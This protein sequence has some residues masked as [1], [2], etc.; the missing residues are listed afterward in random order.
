MS[1]PCPRIS[2]VVPA[3]DEERWLPRLL[4][5]VDRARE[6]Y[7]Q[8]DQAV[9]VIVAD[10]ASTDGTHDVAE[11][12]GCLVEVVERRSIAAV[13]NGGAR[14]ARGGILAFADADTRLH[15]RTFHVIDALLADEDVIGGATGVVFE[16][17]SPGIRCTH[18]MLVLVAMMLRGVR[19]RRP[20]SLDS[21]VVFCRREDFFEV[22]GYREDLLFAED[23]GLLLALTRL[24]RARA[25]T[26]MSGTDAR[27]VSSARKFD[28]Y[29]DWH[30]FRM[31]WHILR[32]AVTGHEGW[33]RSYWYPPRDRS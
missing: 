26:W 16:R 5:S 18:A 24:A 21:G 19:T 33:I 17:S 3:H 14:V 10:N 6:A 27:A 25:Q 20:L 7:G 22:G 28:R 31:P 32:F 12:R 1:E 23:V 8:G 30:F 9:E 13:R 2:L 4:D 15:P 11:S 29:G